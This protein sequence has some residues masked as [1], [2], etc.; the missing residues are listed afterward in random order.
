MPYL[1]FDLD[2][3]EN[4]PAIGQGC[5]LLASQVSHGLLMTW[6]HCWREKTDRITTAHLKA[7]FCGADV[8]E[9]L[10]VFGHI[11][12]SEEGWR[13]RG[14]AKWLKVV[15]ARSANGKANAGNLKR[16]TKSPVHSRQDPGSAPALAASSQQPTATKAKEEDLSV[17][18][19]QAV[20]NAEKPP[21]CP[22]WK[23][24][25]STRRTSARARLREQPDLEVWRGAIKLTHERPFLRGKNK[26]GWKAGPE[27]LL[28]P[29]TLTRLLEGDFAGS[30][31]PP[32]RGPIDPDKDYPTGVLNAPA[33]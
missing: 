18:A 22:A 21:E 3:F 1:A 27:W 19:L 11:E 24:N 17:E 31:P 16:G 6:R 23:G 7:F 20:W 14:A 29:D 25:P 12:A 28:K 8:V 9:M 32:S 2:A 13:V 26:R 15:D 30:D 33:V 10:L 5:G 4:C